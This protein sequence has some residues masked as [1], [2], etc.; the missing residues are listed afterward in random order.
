MV[1]RGVLQR[2]GGEQVAEGAPPRPLADLV[3]EQMGVLLVLDEGGEL[4]PEL[5]E[6]WL[7][8]QQDVEEPGGI[9][10]NPLEPAHRVLP[11]GLEQVGD[12]L[13]LDG[14]EKDY[15]S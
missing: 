6:D 5:A 15:F 10:V 1:D 2:G 7:A 14:R 8:F 13:L 3:G 12:P 11:R 4:R 9:D